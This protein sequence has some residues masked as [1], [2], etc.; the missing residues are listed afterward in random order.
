VVEI[1]GSYI[2]KD[3]KEEY[4]ENTSDSK[5]NIIVS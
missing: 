5:N 3:E 1:K 4:N 2:N